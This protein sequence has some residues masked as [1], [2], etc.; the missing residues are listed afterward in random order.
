MPVVLPTRRRVEALIEYVGRQPQESLGL[1]SAQGRRRHHREARHQRGDGRLPA[2]ALSRR[3]GGHGGASR[4]RA[5]PQR[6][7]ADDPHVRVARDR[8]RPH[9]ARARTSTRA[10]ACSA[11]ATG[12]TPPWAGA[13]AW[14]CG[15]SAAPRRGTPTS[16]PSRIPAS[17]PSA[18][19]RRK[20]TTRGGRCTSSAACPRDRDAVTVFA[21]EGPHSVFC[22]GTPEEML[23]VLVGLH[24]RRSAT[25]TCT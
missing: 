24:V 25:T 10:T 11:T 14:R 8:Q 18:S 17:T 7:D 1:D 19:P 4:P 6:R 12:P 21:C 5:Q 23:H 2:R 9:R 20:R 15:T 13:C 22:Y 3:A 16:P